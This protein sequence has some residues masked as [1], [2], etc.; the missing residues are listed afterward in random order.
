MTQRNRFVVLQWHPK[1]TLD[2]KKKKKKK[3]HSLPMAQEEETIKKIK[4]KYH[5]HPMTS[6]RK[7]DTHNTDHNPRMAPRRIVDK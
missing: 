5:R 3:N 6:R 4:L 2:K 7:L 1:G